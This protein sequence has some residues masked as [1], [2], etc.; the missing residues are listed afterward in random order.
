M[1]TGVETDQ[2]VDGFL[3]GLVPA[4]AIVSHGQKNLGIGEGLHQF[5]AINGTLDNDVLSTLRQRTP[6]DN[7]HQP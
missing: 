5:T 7:N 4:L 6:P 2:I 1:F 3:D